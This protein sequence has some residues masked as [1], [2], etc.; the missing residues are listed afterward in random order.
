MYK[1]GTNILNSGGTVVDTQST[2]KNIV[3]C[4][5]L[6]TD[7]HSD[8]VGTVQYNKTTKAAILVL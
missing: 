6:V 4:C 7:V 1:S 2:A 5:G 8:L 3:S